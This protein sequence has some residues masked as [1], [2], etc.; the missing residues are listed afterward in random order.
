MLK[1][2]KHLKIQAPKWKKT[3]KRMQIRK[4]MKETNHNHPEILKKMKK[5][6]WT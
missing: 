5:I 2:S 4:D 3:R 1:I 6:Y